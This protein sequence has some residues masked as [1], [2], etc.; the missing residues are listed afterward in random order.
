MAVGIIYKPQHS[1]GNVS[2]PET[3]FVAERNVGIV[4]TMQPVIDESIRNRRRRA[5][6]M[7]PFQRKS[8]KRRGGGNPS[9]PTLI[10]EPPIVPTGTIRSFGP[11]GPKYEV[12]ERQQQLEDGDWMVRIRLIE[13]GEEVDYRYSRLI[14]DPKAL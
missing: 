14:E 1:C 8:R 4:D 12:L 3:V 5:A 13:T 2:L 11:L 10:A 9:M 6:G 7:V